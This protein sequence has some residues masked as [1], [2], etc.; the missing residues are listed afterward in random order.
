L[1]C[2]RVTAGTTGVVGTAGVVEVTVV[3]VFVVDWVSE[4]SLELG[5]HEVRA[6]P[7]QKR[8]ISFISEVG[9]WCE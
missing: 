1:A 9:T 3:V 7:T 2:D 8:A 5:P 6:I 4:E